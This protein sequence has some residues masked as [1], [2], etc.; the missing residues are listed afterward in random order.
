[1][2]REQTINHEAYLHGI[3]ELAGEDTMIR[4]LRMKVTARHL[5]RVEMYLQLSLVAGPLTQ[6]RKGNL[7]IGGCSTLKEAI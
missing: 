5:E 6:E 3:F 1:M 2:I 7:D 4:S